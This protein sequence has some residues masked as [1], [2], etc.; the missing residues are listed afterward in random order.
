MINNKFS[1]KN[2]QSGVTLLFS[3]LVM[4]GVSLIAMTVSYLAIQELRASRAVA[5]SEPAI[6]AAE[7]AAETG[8]W[9]MN[10]SSSL[11]DCATNPTPDILSKTLSMKCVTYSDA[12]FQVTPALPGSF[13]LYDPNNINGNTNPGYTFLLV[14]YVS[15]T[16]A[17]TVRVERLDATE[18]V[19]TTTA[20]GSSPA[21]INL[22]TN[23]AQDNRFK[24]IMTSAGSM[25]VDVNTN[26]G[27]PEFPTMNAEGCAT[28]HNDTAGCLQ[29]PDAFR[30][31]LHISLPI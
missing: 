31:K 27:M 10:R 30:R 6:G 24:V 18:V 7:T 5:L 3:V 28:A 20:A 2:S 8:L 19:T 21:T 1:T 9:K 16:T 29:T 23:P 17:L 15:G 14:S 12:V 22:P 25:T 26:L 11:P 13:H 4:S